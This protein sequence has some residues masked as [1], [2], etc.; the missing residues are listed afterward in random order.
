MSSYLSKKIKVIQKKIV[1]ETTALAGSTTES[2]RNIELV[3][4]LGLAEQEINRKNNNQHY[5]KYIEQYKNELLLLI[6]Q[7]LLVI[8]FDE[9]D[10][11][12]EWG[13]ALSAACCL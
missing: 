8:N 11:N 1:G 4:S 9:E 5:M 6:F 2:L 13:H 3:K 7:G 10:D 12:D